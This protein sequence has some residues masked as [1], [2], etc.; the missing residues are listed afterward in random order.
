MTANSSQKLKHLN[1]NCRASSD[2][3]KRKEIGASVVKKVT[4]LEK[5]TTTKPKRKVRKW[6]KKKDGLYGWVMVSSIPEK[7][8]RPQ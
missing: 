5:K 1:G 8:N 7:E 3:Q 4:E 2:V 6:Q